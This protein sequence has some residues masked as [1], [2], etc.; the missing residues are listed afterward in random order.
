MEMTQAIPEQSNDP[1]E[2]LAQLQ[3]MRAGDVDWRQG[4]AWSLVYHAGEAHHELM[5]RVYSLF[6]SDNAL[7]PLA[8]KSLKRMESEVVAM[9]ARMLNGPAEAVGTMSSGGTESILLAVKAA[10]DRARAYK[11]WPRRPEIVAPRTIHPAFAKAA[12]YFGCKLRLVDVDKDFRADVRALAAKISYKTVLI[13]ASAPQY[14]HGMI[15]PIEEIGALAQRKGIPFH[16]DACFG[17]FILP[18]LEKLG[19]SVR[20]FDFRVP[21]V[22]S[23]SADVHKY[24]YAPKG[25]SVVV[26]R[27][28]S[29][30][31]HQFFVSTDF[32]GGIYISPT[33]AGTRPGGAIACAWA[34]LKALG[35]HG[36]LELA[37]QSL[38]AARR[39][40]D[41][42]RATGAL[43]IIGSEDAT[44]VA[45]RSRD[46]AV[47]T[48]AVADQLEARGWVMERQQRPV[49]L[50]LTAAPH[51]RP[52]VAEFLADLDAATTAVRAQPNLKHQGQAAVYGMMAGVPIR[53]AVEAAVRKVME[54]MYQPGAD[55]T[56]LQELTGG[57]AAPG[58]MQSVQRW[59]PM[60]GNLGKRLSRNQ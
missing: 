12:H 56:D 42:I 11:K 34:A 28:M 60:L 45:F 6:L 23:I 22:T 24:G 35:Q 54:G 17:G 31:R 58:W 10:R 2:L 18:W 40:K 51:H 59:A 21:G 37:K 55:G 3:A 38:E 39:L 32:P 53:G 1:D 47:D 8:F 57:Q 52:V 9:T 30:L 13:A 46:P 14:P 48:Y 26:Y 43:E 49:S 36:Y 15:D 33:M 7:N 41:G 29:Y 5:Q 4:R 19:H 25:A 44:I 20:P 50:H 16:V 27:D